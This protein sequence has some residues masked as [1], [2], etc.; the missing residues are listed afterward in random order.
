[1]SVRA[2]IGDI[3]RQVA[4]EQQRTLAQLSDSAK[5]IELGLDSLSFALVVARLEDTFGFDP[6]RALDYFPVTFGE[7]AELYEAYPLS[8]Q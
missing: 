7:F 6:F 2:A 4:T 3:F 8:H 5:L 1:M